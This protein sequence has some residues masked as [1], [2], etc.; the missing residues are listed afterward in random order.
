MFLSWTAVDK[1]FMDGSDDHK[2]YRGFYGNF[3]D[4]DP[5]IVAVR[6]PLDPRIYLA[7][8]GKD[9]QY[10]AN[11][12]RTLTVSSAADVFG[13][14][15]DPR[16]QEVLQFI[17]SYKPL[18]KVILSARCRNGATR[19]RTEVFY[20]SAVAIAAA[21]HSRLD[22]HPIQLKVQFQ[23]PKELL[24]RFLSL[25]H[26]RT[27]ITAISISVYS[28]DFDDSLVYAPSLVSL[29]QQVTFLQINYLMQHDLEHLIEYLCRNQE[30]VKF[31]LK[32]LIIQGVRSKNDRP[33]RSCR[34]LADILQ[35]TVASEIKNLELYNI[36]WDAENTREVSEVLSQH[37]SVRNVALGVQDIGNSELPFSADVNDHLTTIFSAFIEHHRATSPP[38]LSAI[39]ITY[40][41]AFKSNFPFSQV[42]E[43]HLDFELDLEIFQSVRQILQENSN[44]ER[45]ALRNRAGRVAEEEINTL[46]TG[47]CGNESV[48]SLALALGAADDI[49]PILRVVQGIQRGLRQEYE[50]SRVPVSCSRQ[51]D[52]N[53]RDLRVGR[54]SIQ[55]L[56]ELVND[57][58]CQIRTLRVESH[59]RPSGFRHIS[60]QASDVV[61][62]LNAV[63][64]QPNLQ[65]FEL[66]YGPNNTEVMDA[67]PP[68][69]PKMLYLRRLEINFRYE[70]YRAEVLRSVEA[71]KEHGRKSLFMHCATIPLY[72]MSR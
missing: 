6:N 67:L 49:R 11:P 9:Y 44:L 12:I 3:Y 46:A 50:A 62:L 56:T 45:L 4:R 20:H 34:A 70:H 55:L 40:K 51:V 37:K 28:D 18:Q 29:G 64:Q 27:T 52:L 31:K 57:S 39:S 1:D 38:S 25:P 47:L 65:E 63:Q 19:E 22:N 42:K 13:N 68:L 5:S 14:V 41:P 2:R 33:Y 7:N 71:W 32:S 21:C 60:Q 35:S 16:G 23:L 72:I 17:K 10:A 58:F 43:L 69:I 54:E 24:F 15:R 66:S 53:F 59:C 61:S 26:V 48:R 30:A 8:T 36:N